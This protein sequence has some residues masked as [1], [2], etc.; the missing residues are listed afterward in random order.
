MIRR[1]KTIAAGT[2]CRSCGE[3]V[4]SE[5]DAAPWCPGC[6]WNL[7]A[8]DRRR[9]ELGWRWVDR[10]TFR[11]ALRQTRRDYAQWTV[12]GLG[13]PDRVTWVA[14]QAVSLALAGC[15][16]L[17]VGAGLWLSVAGWPKGLVFGVPCLLLAYALRPRL[18]R[19][20][21]D[22]PLLTR[23]AAPT[24]YALVDRVAAAVGTRAPAVIAVSYDLNAGTAEVGLRRDRVL[25]LGLPLWALLPAQQRVAL[26]GHE[27]G[28][29]VNGDLRRALVTQPAL[30]MLGRVVRLM[31]YDYTAAAMGGPAGLALR[32]FF[33]LTSWI[34][35][36]LHLA[37]HSIAA[38][39]GQQAEYR[40]DLIAARVAGT[41]AARDLADS[42]VTLP[43]VL[44]PVNRSARMGVAPAL[45]L[46][47]AEHVRAGLVDRLPGLRQLSVR[48]ETSLFASHPPS[49]LRARML[50]AHRSDAEPAPLVVL[51]PE[52]NFRIDAELARWLEQLRQ[53]VSAR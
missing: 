52:D 24:L 11:W 14:L 45:W 18:G 13:R 37:V 9:A 17:L 42:M 36:L 33:S 31:R 27:L 30:T 41:A 40:A 34:P 6:E 47:T 1:A 12:D 44:E 16:L 3:P 26:L 4:V 7:E 46:S 48:E 8:F 2:P 15:W 43:E 38:R 19:L 35:W 53:A 28:H 49:G 20:P 39:G 32:L 10:L 5:R 25:E 23:Q 22:S 21:E 50:E 29:F 51:S